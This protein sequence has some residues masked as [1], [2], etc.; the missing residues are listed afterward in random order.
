MDHI[1]K[2]DELLKLV[3]NTSDIRARSELYKLYRNCRLI[4][5]EMSKEEVNCR[6][7]RH[8]TARYLELE[9]QLNQSIKVFE[10]WVFFSKLLY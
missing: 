8:T 7:I 3:Q 6:R 5:T 4:T 1:A 9:Q 10:E 2:L